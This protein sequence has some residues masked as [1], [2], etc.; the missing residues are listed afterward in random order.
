MGDILLVSMPW[1]RADYPSTQVGLLK[2]HLARRGIAV[3]AAYPYLDLESRLGPD[4]YL[5]LADKVHP[6][7]GES[8]F[9]ALMDPAL[10]VNG[11]RYLLESEEITAETLVMVRK[12]IGE[13][14]GDLSTSD[15]W[16]G[17]DLV[18]F[19]CSFNQVYASLAAARAVKLRSPSVR[20]VFG[21]AAMH[22]TAGRRYLETYDFIDYVVS[23]PGEEILAELANN[24]LPRRTF[25]E[26]SPATTA[27]SLPDYDEFFARSRRTPPCAIVL[28][29]SRGCNYGACAFCA[30]NDRP[31]YS[32]RTP[33]A[34]LQEVAVTT[35]RYGT[36]SVE[37][38]DTCFPMEFF[39]SGWPE[40]MAEL[41]IECFA[42][43]RAFTSP[44]RAEAMRRAG[45]RQV[46][47]GIESFHSRTLERM[48]KPAGVIANVQ[49]LRVA[50]ASD[51]NVAYNL[52]L[53]FPS[54][55]ARALEELAAL[56]PSL[57]HLQPPTSLVPFALHHGSAVHKFPSRY[58]V[59]GIRPHR[60][61]DA[62]SPAF[63]SGT[64]VP[65]FYDFDRAAPLRHYPEH[66]DELCRSWLSIY[67]HRRPA[68]S[69]S[70]SG[71]AILIQD[72]RAGPPGYRFTLPEP[73]ARIFR[74]LDL[75]RTLKDLQDR[76]GGAQVD[77]ALDWLRERRLIIED[78]HQVLA[79]P[80]KNGIRH[81]RPP[82][83]LDSYFTPAEAEEE[84]C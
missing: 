78:E 22:G 48:H 69:W 1:N 44:T 40:R 28:S 9:A 83:G 70:R 55:D 20:I 29:A 32:A 15:C 60:F 34:V 13:F 39:G 75:P 41:G 84:P 54:T 6:V 73:V 5:R 31:E 68:L 51:I 42:Q 10:A 61:Y 81:L 23:G 59:T 53:D 80:V 8:L 35:R 45:F 56:L 66:I 27:A 3:R 30:Q 52:I 71:D 21:G 50:Y 49:C 12:A 33:D 2:G 46:Q 4:L 25:L 19:T 47:V 37:F 76:F 16:A 17:A 36:T 82:D 79:L 14:I 57:F 74:A 26:T 7:L 11:D 64:L 77:V 67:D 65:L 72:R 18:G 43:V 58:G 24:P 63:A 38:S 62:V